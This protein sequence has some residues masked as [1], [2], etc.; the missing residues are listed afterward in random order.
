[1]VCEPVLLAVFVVFAIIAS[2]WI[3]RAE[4]KAHHYREQSQDYFETLQN[5]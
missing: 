4:L 5:M 2:V 3:V 1:M